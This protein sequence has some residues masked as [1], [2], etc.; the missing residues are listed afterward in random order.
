METIKVGEL[1]SNFSRILERVQNGEEIVISFGKKGK[2]VAVLV[3]Y[4]KYW[5]DSPRPLGI[6]KNRAS[7]KIGDD[8]KMRDEEL[9]KEHYPDGKYT[10][11][12]GLCKVATLDEIEAQGWSLNPGRYV[13]V[14]ELDDDGVNFFV[15]L[16]ELNEELEV[17]NAE[18]S[19]LEKRIAENVIE[20][21]EKV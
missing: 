3:P 4:K 17:L 12:K 1:K 6:L 15:R 8:F 13:G 16:E 18:A 2:K 10:D 19:F 5:Q 11:V 14:A 7:V 21:L 20:L 9:L